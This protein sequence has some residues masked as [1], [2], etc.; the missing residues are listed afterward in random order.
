VGRY[1]VTGPSFAMD[2][3]MGAEAL[4]AFLQQRQAQCVVT[5]PSV[6]LELAEYLAERAMSL[7]QMR[8]VHAF[9]EVLTEGTTRRVAALTGWPI[10]DTYSCEEA[11]NLAASCPGGHG[12][13]VHDESVLLEVVDESGEP[14]RPGETGRVLVTDLQNYGFPLIRYE[15]GDMAVAGAPE[16]CPCGRGLSRLGGIVGRTWSRLLAVDG[17]RHCSSVLR[18]EV[19]DGERAIRSGILGCV[20]RFRFVQ[21]ERGSVEVLVVPADGFGAEHERH[22]VEGVRR[23]LGEDMA[24]SV[25]RVERIERQAGGK[26][27]DAVCTV[28]MSDE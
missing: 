12:Y 1:F 7:P 20:R 13:H 23:R 22:I 11:G 8:Q 16:P 14:C 10:F 9:T 26:F 6:V 25:R 5:F 3:G 2:V 21:T 19:F 27:V 4:A 18:T 24:V 15:L 17:T 28:V